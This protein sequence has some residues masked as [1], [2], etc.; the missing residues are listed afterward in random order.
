MRFEEWER[1]LVL[2]Q[3]K[4]L[5]EL[6]DG[7]EDTITS[8]LEAYGELNG[9]SAMARYV[10]VPCGIAAQMVL[11]GLFK[12][13]DI[14]APHSKEIC[15]PIRETLEAHGMGLVEQEITQLYGFYVTVVR[16]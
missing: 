12:E 8:T 15:D 10:G 13:S 16:S 3:Q 5:A 9:H 14:F 11:D 4:F 6:A 7:T 1:D 2:F